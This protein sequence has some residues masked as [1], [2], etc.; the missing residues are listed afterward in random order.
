MQCHKDFKL[1]VFI[2]GIISVVQNEFSGVL[3]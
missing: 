2:P 3:E 1:A